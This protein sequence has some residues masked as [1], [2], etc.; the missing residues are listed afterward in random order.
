[1]TEPSCASMDLDKILRDQTP[2]PSLRATVDHWPR[3]PYASSYPGVDHHPNQHDHPRYHRR[4]PPMFLAPDDPMFDA[5]YGDM[6]EP[7]NPDECASCG[8]LTASASGVCNACKATE[9][10]PQGQA[11]RLFEPAPNQL[12]GQLSFQP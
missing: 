6:L 11:V 5:V 8:Q 9:R 3:E 12:T 4:R 1:M 10:A 7:P 2:G